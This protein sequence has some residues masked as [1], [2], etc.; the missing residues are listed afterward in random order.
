MNIT[1]LTQEILS[2]YNEPSNFDDLTQQRFVDNQHSVEHSALHTQRTSPLKAPLSS[3]MASCTT[4][5]STAGRQGKRG[6]VT[7]RKVFGA[8]PRGMFL[9]LLMSLWAAPKLLAMFYG[10]IENCSLHIIHGGRVEIDQWIAKE[11]RET[12]GLLV[13]FLS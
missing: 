13:M 11:H 12:F 3:T 6:Q 8:R 4:L 10:K 9:I 7:H 1:V 5:L 2:C